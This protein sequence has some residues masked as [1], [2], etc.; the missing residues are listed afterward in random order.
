MI[1]SPLRG[2]EPQG[3]IGRDEP[4]AGEPLGQPRLQGGAPV[5]QVDHVLLAPHHGA[6]QLPGGDVAVAVRGASEHDL[7]VEGPLNLEHV[8][9]APHVDHKVVRPSPGAAGVGYARL[10]NEADVLREEEFRVGQQ[11]ALEVKLARALRSN[12]S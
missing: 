9:V 7:V 10:L 5:Q 4:V 3:E 8:H 1:T 12:L 6:A 2:R 11:H